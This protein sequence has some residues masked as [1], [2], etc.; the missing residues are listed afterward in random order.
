MSTLLDVLVV[1]NIMAAAMSGVF[2][3]DS[4]CNRAYKGA[5]G[6]AL[7]MALNIACVLIRVSDWRTI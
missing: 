1:L 6:N 2:V 5:L 3:R 4:I 7:C